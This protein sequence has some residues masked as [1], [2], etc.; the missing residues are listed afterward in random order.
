MKAIGIG[1][2]AFIIVIII[3]A[4]AGTLYYVSLQGSAPQQLPD[5][6][7]SS[8]A[9]VAQLKGSMLYQSLSSGQLTPSMLSEPQNQSS[10]FNVTYSGKALITAKIGGVSVPV[11]VPMVIN[12]QKFGNDSRIWASLTGLPVVGGINASIIRIGNVTYICAPSNP[13]NKSSAPQCFQRWGGD[14][15]TLTLFNLLSL[16]TSNMTLSVSS[17]Y[18][19]EYNQV[20]CVFTNSTLVLSQ[21][22]Q[23][24]GSSSQGSGNLQSCIALENNLPVTFAFSFSANNKN[25]TVSSVMLNLVQSATSNAVSDAAIRA[26]PAPVTNSTQ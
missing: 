15:S 23:G 18:P 19:S 14:S 11:A 2:I 21:A 10:Q 26:L 16:I 17:Y 7:A 9:A 12:N 20:S 13:L 22:S 5:L 1:L 25:S 8:S 24:L 6:S 3:G 4:A